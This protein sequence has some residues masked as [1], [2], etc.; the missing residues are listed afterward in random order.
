VGSKSC[1]AEAGVESMLMGLSFCEEGSVQ[2]AT[3]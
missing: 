1:A 3:S 2:T